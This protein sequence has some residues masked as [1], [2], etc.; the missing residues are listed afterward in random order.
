MPVRQAVD[1][2]LAELLPLVAE[3]CAVDRHPFDRERVLRGLPP[4]LADDRCGQVRLADAGGAT[5]AAGPAGFAVVT[6]SWSLESGGRDCILDELYVR[7][8]GS[9]PGTRLREIPAAAAAAGA[10]TVF[11]ETEALNA[12][13]RGS[14]ARLGFATEDPVGV[15]RALP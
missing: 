5:A 14:C 13:V 12:R 3:F 6:W 10:S 11:P 8:R 1:A 4:L 2:D 15:R 9:G 7:D